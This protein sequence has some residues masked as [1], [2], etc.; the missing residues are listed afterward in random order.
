MNKD[1]GYPETSADGVQ[2]LTTA[3]G[4]SLMNISAHILKA[5]DEKQFYAEDEE[6]AILLMNGSITLQWENNKATVTRETC[7]DDGRETYCLH[8]PKATGIILEAT[9]DSDVLVMSAKNDNVFKSRLYGPDDIINKASEKDLCGGTCDRQVTTIINYSIAPYSN[10]VIGEIFM[11]QG[12]WSCYPP[13][14]HPQPEVFYYRTDKPQGFGA[15]FIG[16]NVYLIK[17]RSYACITNALPHP[18]VTAAGYKTYLVW[19]IRHLPGNPWVSMDEAE[20]HKWLH[21]AKF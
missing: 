17:D 11:R 15:C 3:D 18:Q 19:I 8:V 12:S 13:H 16:D 2:Q 10:M 1:F 20:E 7:F 14:S 5:G 6:V 21:N 9:S 4:D